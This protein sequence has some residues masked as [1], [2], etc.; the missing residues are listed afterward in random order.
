MNGDYYRCLNAYCQKTLRSVLVLLTK[1]IQIN[2]TEMN[3]NKYTK[4]IK[5]T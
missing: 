4:K 2:K 5:K 3:S 1:T